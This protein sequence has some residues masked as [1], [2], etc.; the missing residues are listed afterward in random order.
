MCAAV[1]CHMFAALYCSVLAALYCSMLTAICCQMF[2]ALYCSMFV[3]LY[4]PRQFCHPRLDLSLHPTD[5]LHPFV[6]CPMS[7]GRTVP[8]PHVHKNI[9]LNCTCYVCQNA[10]SFNKPL[11]FKDDALP[12]PGTDMDATCYIFMLNG[13]YQIG[14]EEGDGDSI[15]PC[16]PT[17]GGFPF[18]NAMLM[19]ATREELQ[20]YCNMCYQAT[21]SKAYS[22][23]PRSCGSGYSVG[24]GS[25]VVVNVS[26][27]ATPAYHCHLTMSNDGAC[28][29]VQYKQH[30]TARQYYMP[31]AVICGWQNLKDFKVMDCD[32]TLVAGTDNGCGVVECWKMAAEGI[33]C[34]NCNGCQNS[35]AR[36]YIFGLYDP[37]S[38]Q[39][40]A[41][42]H[43]SCG[44]ARYL[45]GTQPNSTAHKQA[46]RMCAEAI[47]CPQP[48]NSTA[49]INLT[50]NQC[51]LYCQMA[52][53]GEKLAND[54]RCPLPNPARRLL[55]VSEGSAFDGI[56]TDMA[57]AEVVLPKKDN[58]WSRRMRF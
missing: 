14:Y 54:F 56:K 39:T 9:G 27:Q 13:T 43:G 12:I 10:W 25:G 23:D 46:E 34:G 53:A 36:E 51:A 58:A 32:C 19:T 55:E 47:L 8:L 2:A 11:G 44:L 1:Y 30:E 6:Y 38:W 29:Y 17:Q 37:G 49:T 42:Y 33:A 24:Q 40:D 7:H 16:N 35:D 52:N 28:E 4:V 45:R 5:S 22:H 48:Q 31:S 15:V 41:F 18:T 50:Q 20:E 21:C 57:S 26:L 3:A